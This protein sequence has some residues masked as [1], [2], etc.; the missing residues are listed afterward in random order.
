MK[1]NIFSIVMILVCSVIV[2]CS[3]LLELNGC[4]GGILKWMLSCFVWNSVWWY[5]NMCLVG[6]L[7]FECWF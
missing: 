7:V 6:M 3:I 4:V 1:W 5:V 2:R